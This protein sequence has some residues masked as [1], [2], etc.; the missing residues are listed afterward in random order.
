MT[1]SDFFNNTAA[2]KTFIRGI[3]ASADISSF[4]PVYRPAAKK[5]INL[6]GQETY[7]MLKAYVATP[8]QPT[9]ADKDLA[10]E[11]TRGAIANLLA[12]SWF[13]FDAGRRNK[14][15]E[16]LYRY[17]ENLIADAYLENAWAELDQL[18]LLLESGP[19]KFTDF[20]DSLLYKQREKLYIK[21]AADF[22]KY[23]NIDSSSYFYYNSI[24]IQVEVEK[25]KIA[26]RFRTIETDEELL[27]LIKKA[28]AFETVSIACQRFDYSEL[29]KGIRN[30]ISKEIS[31][32]VNRNE[33]GDI[34][35]I[36]SKRLH[37][38]AQQ[39][40]DKIDIIK[41]SAATVIPPTVPEE[42]ITETNKFYTTF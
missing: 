3:D 39:F 10:I 42:I 20:A 38:K 1:I 28:I 24:F 27:Y 29:P 13:T 11:Y 8:P 4:A 23:Y 6:I 30:D 5:Y 2:V 37:A 16:K 40:L 25:E 17:Q 14:T 19:E 34:K 26:S 18:V 33:L 7:D 9:D 15:D 21:D 41:K 31:G 36:V 22:N 35:D 12:I 32:S